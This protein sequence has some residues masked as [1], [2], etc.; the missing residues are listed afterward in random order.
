MTKEWE[1][2]RE[3]TRASEETE[4]TVN[5]SMLKS[6]DRALRAADILSITEGRPQRELKEK[7]M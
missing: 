6:S 1:R 7:D 3:R 4:A 2:E 5:T